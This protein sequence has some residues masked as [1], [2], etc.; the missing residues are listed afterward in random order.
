LLIEPL[1]AVLESNVTG[2]ELALQFAYKVTFPLGVIDV[3][4]GVYDVPP[5]PLELLY[6][7]RKVNPVLVKLPLLLCTVVESPVVTDW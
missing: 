3:T 1:V 2:K 7:P 5:D 4:P 6:Q